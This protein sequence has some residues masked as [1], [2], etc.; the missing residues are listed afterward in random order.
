LQE[1]QG[2]YKEKVKQAQRSLSDD[3]SISADRVLGLVKNAES[4]WKSAPKD[5]KIEI[6]KILSSNQRL[7]DLTVEYDLRKP[8]GVIEEI[9]KNDDWSA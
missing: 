2:Y 6:I 4:L 3:L 8:F 5:R 1:E 9:S 7:T